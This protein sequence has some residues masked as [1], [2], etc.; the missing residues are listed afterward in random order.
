MSLGFEVTKIDQNFSSG[1]EEKRDCFADIERY[2]HSNK[3]QGKICAIYGLRRTGKTVLMKQCAESLP[4]SEKEK[5]LYINCIKDGTEFD[6]LTD[7]IR[8]SI[9]EGYKYFFVDEITFTD[10]F[11]KLGT[12][13]SDN[14]VG[15]NDAR[16]VVTGTDSLG[17]A[18]TAREKLYDRIELIHTTYMSFPEYS[19][20]TGCESL[21]D[22]IMYGSTLSEG[23]YEN[24]NKMQEYV[25][26]AVVGNIVNSLVK[27][28]DVSIY[29]PVLTN[30]Y[31][32]SQI[33][34]ELQ[35]II[36]RYSQTGTTHEIRKQFKSP[37][38]GD[39]KEIMTHLESGI[40]IDKNL[41]DKQINQ[42]LSKILQ[43][44]TPSGID[45]SGIEAIYKLLK[46]VDVF[47]EIPDEY[48][49]DLEIFT[50]P[51]MY[52]ANI[53]Y[54]IDELKKDSNW[55]PDT[56]IKQRVDMLN[57]AYQ[58]AMGKIMENIVLS[59]VYHMLCPNGQ[60]EVNKITN[61][62]DNRWYVSKVAQNIDGKNHEADLIIFDTKT[63]HTCLFEI[64]HSQNVDEHQTIH[65]EDPGFIKYV[66]SAFGPVVKKAVLY[67][68]ETNGSLD[69]P[70]VSAKEFLNN[71][72][73]NCKEKDFLP[74]KLVE[75]LA[76]DN[77]FTT[78]NMGNV[79]KKV[80]GDCI[81]N[82]AER[83]KTTAKHKQKNL[84]KDK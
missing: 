40:N 39:G 5:A 34:N 17:L 82:Y 14:F 28:E 35:R 19:R 48:G 66:E 26:T 23:T 67:N 56:P 65:L 57:K 3:P 42:E 61:G 12:I 45:E 79:F 33:V 21:D 62:S 84:E 72:Y 22:Y 44:E 7:F 41:F 10:D 4:S 9:R 59:D 60:G 71:M 1:Y 31:K 51:G 69:I 27:S 81:T 63:K 24:R 2:I 43:T 54:A 37:P 38:I 50:H 55:L 83:E 16:V 18:L 6:D 75:K 58:S 78:R 13:L 32:P 73:V 70:R 47:S 76:Y 20:I 64:K 80:S 30:I 46:D 74:E 15:M 68:G 52:H 49:R 8:N 29:P 53:K 25:N 36:N 77:D 11:Q